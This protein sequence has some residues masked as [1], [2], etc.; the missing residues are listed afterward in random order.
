MKERLKARGIETGFEEEDEGVEGDSEDEG[1][2][3][4]DG[5]GEEDGIDDMFEG[6][7]GGR[8]ITMG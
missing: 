7:G 6:A 4:E 5:E 3:G 2:L 8:M 1:Q